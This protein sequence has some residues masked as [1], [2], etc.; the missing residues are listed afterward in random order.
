MNVGLSEVYACCEYIF[1]KTMC[2]KLVITQ[3][4]VCGEYLHERMKTYSN[5]C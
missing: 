2:F 1:K 3:F 4:Q 5:V